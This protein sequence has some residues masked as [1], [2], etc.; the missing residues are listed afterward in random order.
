M[1]KKDGRTTPD[2]RAGRLQALLAERGVALGRSQAMEVMAALEG[3]RGRRGAAHAPAAAGALAARG[4]PVG[5]EVHSDDRVFEARFDARGYLAGAGA[6]DLAALLDCGWGGDYPADRVAEFEGGERGDAGV[7]AVLDYPTRLRGMGFECR[8][9][10]GEAEAWLRLFR[11]RAFAKA[12]LASERGDAAAGWDPLAALAGCAVV[13][14]AGGYRWTRPDA[15]AGAS[16]TGTFATEEDAWDAAAVE[17]ASDV[18][19]RHGLSDEQWHGTPPAVRAFL[20]EAAFGAADDARRGGPAGSGPRGRGGV[21]R[22]GTA[23]GGYH[24]G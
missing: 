7:A 21:G 12:V 16:A 19:G 24:G 2:A 8:V 5:A 6:D 4:D 14:A 1:A 18:M 9:D 3:G 13:P 20:A 10:A 23:S 15:A 22:Q 17:V 11:P